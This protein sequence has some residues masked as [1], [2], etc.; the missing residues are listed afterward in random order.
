MIH[1][2]ITEVVSLMS[3]GYITNLLLGAF[4]PAAYTIRLWSHRAFLLLRGTSCILTAMGNMATNK[5][6][7]IVCFILAAGDRFPIVIYIG[8]AFLLPEKFVRW[9]VSD[10]NIIGTSVSPTGSVV[11]TIV[12]ILKGIR[13]KITSL[14]HHQSPVHFSL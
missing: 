7:C 12:S 3:A 8:H 5:T 1:I 11:Y 2:M 13:R 14:S 9:V 6:L 4:A 10:L